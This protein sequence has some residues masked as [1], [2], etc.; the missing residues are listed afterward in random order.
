MPASEALLWCLVPSAALIPWACSEGD[1]VPLTMQAAQ[2]ASARHQLT[3]KLSLVL[4]STLSRTQQLPRS[5]VLSL[6]TC[7]LVLVM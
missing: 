6:S 4:K 7:S 5:P 1:P 2:L 3:W